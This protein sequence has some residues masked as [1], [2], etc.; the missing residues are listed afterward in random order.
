MKATKPAKARS[1]SSGE[2]IF[3]SNIM[4]ISP[5]AHPIGRVNGRGISRWQDQ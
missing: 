1:N 2:T 5:N 4:L 3:L